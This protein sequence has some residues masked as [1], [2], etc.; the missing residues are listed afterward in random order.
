M[1]LILFSK[2]EEEDDVMAVASWPGLTEIVLAD[3]PLIRHHVGL[4]PLVESFLINRLGMR[5]HR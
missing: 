2:I 1:S 5:I 4:P 3:N